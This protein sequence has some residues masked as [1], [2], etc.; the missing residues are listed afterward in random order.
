MNV[1]DIIK[2]INILVSMS[3]YDEALQ[4]IQKDLG[5]IFGQEN[6]I[7]LFDEDFINTNQKLIKQLFN[8][9]KAEQIKINNEVI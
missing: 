6:Y 9:T 3:K 1:S 8:G 2:E 4:K 5:Q 7:E